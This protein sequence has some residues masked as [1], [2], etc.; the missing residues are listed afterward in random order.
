MDKLGYVVACIYGSILVS[1]DI[2]IYTNINNILI[3]YKYIKIMKDST[4]RIILNNL[5]HTC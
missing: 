4:E 5:I 3:I 1:Y 2:I